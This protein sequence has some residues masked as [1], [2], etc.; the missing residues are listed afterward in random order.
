MVGQVVSRDNNIIPTDII[1]LRN[2]FNVPPIHV[3]FQRWKNAHDQLISAIAAYANACITLESSCSRARLSYSEDN[4][5]LEAVLLTIELELPRIEEQR[6]SLVKSM[7]T[8]KKAR[9]LSYT[10]VPANI[11]PPSI[12]VS[13]FS[14]VIDSQHANQT[15]HLP[16]DLIRPHPALTMSC[17]STGWHNLVSNS[18]SLWS[19]IF[20]HSKDLG[21]F[22]T[23]MA[24]HRA[25]SALLDVQISLP[26]DV[27]GDWLWCLRSRWE[28]IRSLDL[29][30]SN[31]DALREVLSIWPNDTLASSL[32]SLSAK[33]IKTN[34]PGDAPPPKLL[35]EAHKSFLQNITSMSLYG[36]YFDWDSAAFRGLEHLQLVSIAN[37]TGPTINQIAHILRSSPRLRSLCLGD[38]RIHSDEAQETYPVYLE[39]LTKLSIMSFAE[40]DLC[41][42]LS[43]VSPGPR[44]LT[45]HTN[46]E[47]VQTPA[48]EAYIEL[49]RRS[50]IEAIY[51]HSRISRNTVTNVFAS[52]PHLRYIYFSRN[53]HLSVML[54]ALSAPQITRVDD[55]QDITN[56]E[57]PAHDRVVIRT[58]I[59]PSYDPSSPPTGT[60]Y[61]LLETLYFHDCKFKMTNSEMGYLITHQPNL[62]IKVQICDPP[63]LGD[64]L[65]RYPV[66]L[67]SG[68]VYIRTI[69]A[70]KSPDDIPFYGLNRKNIYTVAKRSHSHILTTGTLVFDDSDLST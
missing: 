66:T 49:F 31:L 6:Q 40:A 52:L 38:M 20:I 45:L 39:Y 22:A 34:Y 5:D 55:P 13:V 15:H 1:L 69:P 7:A 12:L 60:P 33:I 56:E 27:T 23:Q 37:R 10:L 36:G 19:S 63:N 35:P 30:L 4:G 68:R 64:I 50:K 21:R 43:I 70:N 48:T 26:K 32:R 51:F 47:L 42:I 25:G 41:K 53:K 11:L 8:L 62:T 59:L 3:A 67:V 28:Q 29:V 57:P 44:P 54:Q 65:S 14:T 17:V 58:S 46:Y 2:P 16:E 24:L 9:N 61:P 18:P